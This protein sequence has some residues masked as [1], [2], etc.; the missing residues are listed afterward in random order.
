MVQEW[1]PEGPTEQDAVLTIAKCI[2]CKRRIQDYISAKI[3]ERS[4]DPDDIAYNEARV[5]LFLLKSSPHN[6]EAVFELALARLPQRTAG[7]LKTTCLP[8]NFKSHAKWKKA[9]RHELA[10]VVLPTIPHQPAELLLLN[11]GN[12][13]TED[14]FKSAL[15]TEERLSATIARAVKQL[16]QA[17]AMKQMLAS[18]SLGAQDQ[19]ARNQL[20]KPADT[21]HP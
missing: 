16:V 4:L 13:L 1:Q 3:F 10:S 7:H 17:K 8:A 15:G 6:F 11:A 18:P 21:P 9:L 19:T 5:L 20:P 14:L 12:V 2:L